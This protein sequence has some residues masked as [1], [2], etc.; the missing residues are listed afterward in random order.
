MK[1]VCYLL[2]RRKLGHGDDFHFG[3]S[4]SGKT[5]RNRG[6]NEKK[7]RRG[8]MAERERGRGSRKGRNKNI[9]YTF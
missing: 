7:T 6:S 3:H 1:F 5:Q 2:G 8:E 9:N 4:C